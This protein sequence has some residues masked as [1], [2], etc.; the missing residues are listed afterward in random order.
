[1]NLNDFAIDC[2]S[3]GTEFDAPLVAIGAVNFDRTT[4]KLGSTFYREIELSSSLKSGR[5]GADTLRWWIKQSERAKVIFG[6]NADQAAL[7]TV[8]LD[9]SSWMRGAGKGVPRVW[10]NGPSNDVTWIEHAMT[11]GGHGL[12]PPWHFTNVRDDRTIRELAEE[13]AGFDRST[14]KDVGEHHNALDD[15]I[16][17]ANV[18]CACYKALQVGR[19]AKK[20]VTPVVEDDDEL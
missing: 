9:F 2:E 15:A 11:V 12:T 5:V 6:R 8:L 20:A 19:V 14:I 17:Q 18:I 1:M 10:A 7:A 16:Y 13:I 3:L 4:G